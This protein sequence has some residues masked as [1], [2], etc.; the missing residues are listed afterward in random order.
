MCLLPGHPHPTFISCPLPGHT[1][2]AL[3]L[4]LLVCTHYFTSAPWSYPSGLVAPTCS[5]LLIHSHSFA[6]THLLPLIHTHLFAPTHSLLYPGHMC[7]ALLLPLICVCLFAP[8][9][10]S[11]CPCYLVTLSAGFCWS[12]LPGLTC[13]AFV[14]AHF[15]LFVCIRYI[16]STQKITI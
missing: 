10:S 12:L 14:C 11:A 4:L 5:C 2:L 7:L 13:L 1:H 9:W 8:T 6:P 16:V 3:L 15:S